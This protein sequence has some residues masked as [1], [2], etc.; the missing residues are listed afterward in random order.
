LTTGLAEL[1]E[2]DRGTQAPHGG[3]DKRHGEGAS[4]DGGVVPIGF[5][6]SAD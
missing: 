4:E 6:G 5:D 2:D 1:G 3:G